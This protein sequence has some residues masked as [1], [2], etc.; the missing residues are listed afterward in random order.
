[1]DTTIENEIFEFNG[2]KFRR[3]SEGF[4]ERLDFDW[5]WRRV[6]NWVLIEVLEDRFMELLL[7]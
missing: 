4:W 3:M 2:Y 1:M 5:E 6:D 7:E